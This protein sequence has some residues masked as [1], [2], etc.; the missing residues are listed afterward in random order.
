[1]PVQIECISNLPWPEQD[2]IRLTMAAK[3]IIH[4]LQ[5]PVKFRM[6]LRAGRQCLPVI[7]R[8]S[9][10]TLCWGGSVAIPSHVACGD[11]RSRYWPNSVLRPFSTSFLPQNQLF[12]LFSSNGNLMTLAPPQA[13]LEWNHSAEDITRLTDN[14]IEEYRKI[15]DS[16][17]G[18]DSKDCA[19]E[20]VSLCT[21]CY[22]SHTKLTYRRC[23]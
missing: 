23:L 14:A 19:F 20:S 6:A 3:K 21:V 17:G 8:W 22:S 9:K 4:Q 18:L 13:P 10:M 16:V 5:R 1:M 7:A 2:K 11:I 12:S 15:M